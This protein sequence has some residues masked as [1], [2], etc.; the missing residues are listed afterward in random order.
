MGRKPIG[1]LPMTDAERQRR[2][3]SGSAT[4]KGTKEPGR[5][6]LALFETL[7]V[8]RKTKSEEII[9][10]II[11]GCI[12]AGLLTPEWKKK[13]PTAQDMEQIT[14]WWREFKIVSNCSQ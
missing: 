9:L 11:R 3:R 2:H 6:M 8:I 7:E 14:E 10:D 1:E 5:R 13:E 4:P 12:I